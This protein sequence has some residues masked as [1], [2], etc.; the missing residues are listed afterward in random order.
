[1]Q[2]T[3]LNEVVTSSLN[4][5][6]DTRWQVLTG[7]FGIKSNHL[8]PLFQGNVT[9]EY[10]EVVMRELSGKAPVLRKVSHIRTYRDW[11]EEARTKPEQEFL[12]P[13]YELHNYINKYFTDKEIVGFYVHGSISTLDFV[14]YYSDFDT[15]VIVRKEVLEDNKW[16]ADF[17][18][19]LTKSNT[20]L[21][22][23][24]PFQHHGHFVITEYD[25]MAY[26]ESLFPIELFKYT[27][28][29]SEYGQPLEFHVINEI[30]GINEAIQKKF[31][32]YCE[33]WPEIQRRN[34]LT[35]FDIKNLVQNIIILAVLY[36]EVRD[37]KCYYK[38]EIFENNLVRNDF[39]VEEWSL[40]ERASR[41]RQ[42][43]P[44][45]SRFPF[46]LRKM[47]GFYGHPRIL[48][49]LHKWYD[50]GQAKA[51]MTLLGEDVLTRAQEL[52]KSVA[53]KLGIEKK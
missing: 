46:W 19:R 6:C 52:V 7:L 5:Y 50:G 15:L 22:L 37:E 20:Y 21:Y 38:R 12:K 40:I 47:I 43:F 33:Y 9:R 36:A 31:Y 14:P 23:L 48:H 25:M 29:L 34:G 11:L 39:T 35:A 28:E 1:M 49:L 4:G 44:L 10:K 16:L 30:G 27:T 13:A 42:D 17:K 53:K 8:Q 41:V 2:L 45:K 3:E 24:D 26:Y 32:Y 18:K 51:M